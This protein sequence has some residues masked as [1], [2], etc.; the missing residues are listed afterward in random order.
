MS[1]T[2][3][4]V[5]AGEWVITQQWQGQNAYKFTM[6]VDANGLLTV[7]GG[8]TGVISQIGSGS[9]LSIAIANYKQGIVAAYSG[10]IVGS[11]M[12]GVVSG[13]VGGGTVSTGS[14]SAVTADHSNAQAGTF[15]IGK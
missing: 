2:Q 1:N 9:S 8:F 14:W 15:S 12:G 11:A 5:T 3:S 13:T 10:N 7:D 6:T 4:C